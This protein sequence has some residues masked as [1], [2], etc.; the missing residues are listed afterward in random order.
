MVAMRSADK[1]TKLLVVNALIL[2]QHCEG[3]EQQ[4]SDDVNRFPAT[5]PITYKL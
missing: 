2:S 3:T 1:A 5:K 4:V